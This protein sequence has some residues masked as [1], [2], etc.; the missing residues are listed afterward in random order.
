MAKE[1]HFN[2]NLIATNV[3]HKG[4][5][6]RMIVGQMDRQNRS[7]C[8]ACKAYS[9]NYDVLTEQNELLKVCDYC[10]GQLF[11]TNVE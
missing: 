11:V 5:L 3:Y 7:T 10:L 1:M 9:F 8:A 6:E 2:V 4:N